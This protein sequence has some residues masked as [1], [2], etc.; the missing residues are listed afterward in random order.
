MSSPVPANTSKHSGLMML[1]VTLV[2]WM[3][4]FNKDGNI[5]PNAP[6]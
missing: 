2:V 5:P 4:T 6:N 1:A 3:G